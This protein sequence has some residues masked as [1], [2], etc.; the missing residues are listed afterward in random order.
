M[1]FVIRIYNLRTK[2]QEPRSK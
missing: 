2:S 1:A